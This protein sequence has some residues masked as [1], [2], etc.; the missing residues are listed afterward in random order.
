MSSGDEFAGSSSEE[1]HGPASDD[2]FGGAS[3]S[4]AEVVALPAPRQRRRQLTAPSCQGPVVLCMAIA[5]AAGAW[6]TADPP[7]DYSEPFALDPALV[8]A[9]ALR[10]RLLGAAEAAVAVSGHAPGTWLLGRLKQS[11]RRSTLLGY[12]LYEVTDFVKLANPIAVSTPAVCNPF[13]LRDR[14]ADQPTTST[15]YPTLGDFVEKCQRRGASTIA[16]A[17][18]AWLAAS[19]FRSV[20]REGLSLFVHGFPITTRMRWGL[21]LPGPQ[22]TRRD[23]AAFKREQADVAGQLVVRRQSRKK[24]LKGWPNQLPAQLVLDWLRTSAFISDV[25]ETQEAATAFAKLFARSSEETA[26]QMVARLQTVGVTVL[27]ESRVRA[28]CVAMRFYHVWFSRCSSCLAELDLFLYC[29]GSPQ[30]RGRELYAATVDI[31]IGQMLHCRTLLPIVFLARDEMASTYKTFGLLYQLALLASFELLPYVAKRVR[32]ILTDGGVERYIPGASNIL[33]D[34]YGICNVRPPSAHVPGGRLFPRA[35]RLLGWRH[36]FDLVI[37]KGLCRL[38]WFPRWLKLLKSITYFVRNDNLNDE[39]CKLFRAAGLHG[40]ATLVAQARV[41]DFAKW[42]WN[43]LH[44]ACARPS[45]S[46]SIRSQHTSGLR[47]S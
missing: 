15:E 38:P 32:S 22:P 5:T 34:F 33:G 25:K 19:V 46:S 23:V 43:T 8:G 1:G 18:A 37:R 2:E 9:F 20:S 47:G 11:V 30:W 28:D 6:Q 14:A 39:L 26:E 42:R 31:I 16:F 27:R 41:P 4:D 45:R 12:M 3:G 35:V 36:Q 21:A 24:A 10:W 40:V 44:L 17:M 7:E 13:A 29:D